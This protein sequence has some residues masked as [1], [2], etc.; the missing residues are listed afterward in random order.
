[1][2]FK[3]RKT[4]RGNLKAVSPVIATIIIVAI[5]ITMSI[6]V[7]YWLL[8]LGSSFTKYEKVEFTTAYS[9]TMKND[10]G[11]YFTVNMNIKNTGSAAA[12]V[13]PAYILYNGKPAV[14]YASSTPEPSFAM[15]TLQPGESSV[16]LTIYLPT[17]ASSS[18]QS[19]MTV[20]VTLH[21]TAG[22]DYPKVVTLP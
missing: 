22:H 1:M 11:T 10:T 20:E 4:F 5:A 18:W 8:G 9:G 13:D 21:T 12:T 16:P 14:A 2:K 7:A 3:I 15:F 17:G 19:G 6:A